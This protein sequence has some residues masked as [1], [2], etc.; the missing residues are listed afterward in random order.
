MAFQ[1]RAQQRVAA[2]RRG[3]QRDIALGNGAG[4]ARRQDQILAAFARV[5]AGG[6]R[7]LQRH[8]PNVDDVAVERSVVARRRNLEHDRSGILGV[9]E[10]HEVDRV[11]I[12]RERLVVPV[13]RAR[14]ID[15]LV[16]LAR[17][18]GEHLLQHQVVI[19]GRHA[20]VD[21]LDGAAL[22]RALGELVGHQRLRV[23]PVQG[24]NHSHHC[25]PRYD[26]RVCHTIFP[27]QFLSKDP[28][29]T[30]D[31]SISGGGQL[32][33]PVQS[34]QGNHTGPRWQAGMD[35]M[36]ATSL[37]AAGFAARSS[38]SS[39]RES[40]QHPAPPPAPSS[41]SWCPVWIP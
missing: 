26:H 17:S 1:V 38:C 6:T 23:G 27:S 3:P 39:C 35:A 21:G 40:G 15:D 22:D 32:S 20:P 16:H 14:P 25:E 24:C 18:L 4:V 36:P 29:C 34:C 13:E 31:R 33:Y 41:A 19:D 2:E 8:L 7:V 30:A 9:E 12:G 28:N 10:R 37:R 11:R 5:G